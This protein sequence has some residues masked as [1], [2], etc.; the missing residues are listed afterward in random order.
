MINEPD[1]ATEGRH[2][3]IEIERPCEGCGAELEICNHC[4]GSDD[5]EGGRG[6][7]GYYICQDEDCP[8]FEFC[9]GC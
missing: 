2:A 5:I 8:E 9:C 3:L 1:I 7:R 4:S 6:Q